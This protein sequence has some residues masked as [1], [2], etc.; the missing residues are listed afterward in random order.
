MELDRVDEVWAIVNSRALDAD[1]W[2]RAAWCAMEA[3]AWELCAAFADRALAIN[4]QHFYGLFMRAEALSE[5]DREVE[6]VAAYHALRQSYPNEH[7]AYEKLGLL[8]ALAGEVTEA[9]ALA[10]RAVSLG[11]FC[12][13]A[14]ATRGYIHFLRRDE[15][16]ALADLE[17][18]W[19]RADVDRRRGSHTFWWVLAALQH[20]E[21]TAEMRRAEAVAQ[22]KTG[23]KRRHIAQVD[24]TLRA[25][26]A[27]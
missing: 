11:S 25:R 4:P 15:A 13:F 3:Q 6:A 22:A 12:P 9:L 23:V 19:N 17:T 21:T 14:W 7:N 2:G 24:A 27:V 5:L 16:S 8:L 10:D 20:D 18:G 26:V 1:G